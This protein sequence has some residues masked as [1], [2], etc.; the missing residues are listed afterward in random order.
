MG[1]AYAQGATSTDKRSTAKEEGT[2]SMKHNTPRKLLPLLMFLVTAAGLSLTTALASTPTLTAPV[3]LGTAGSFAILAKSGISSVPQ[4]VI[5]GDIGVSPITAA[6]ITGFSL[7]ADA[8]N[9]YSTSAQVTGK[10]YAADYASPT[11]IRL[12]TAVGDMMTAYTD[13]AGRAANHTNLYAG[14]ISGRTL[15]PGVYKWNTALR[16]NSN[17]TL[18]GGPSAVFIFQVSKGITQ[19]TY[20]KIILSGGVQ[21]K[22]IIWQSAET[23]AIGSGA[24]FE[25]TVL[26]KTNITLGT[27]ASINGRLFAQTA[28]TLIKSTVVAR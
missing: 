15:A 11:P 16:I 25:G 27:K 20:T 8:S 6:A 18:K 7:T 22:N 12:G 21:A 10:V 1:E 5:T 17:V 19:A 4:S 26:G 3:R 23:V 24:H 2:P 9:V 14:D 28:V 13:A